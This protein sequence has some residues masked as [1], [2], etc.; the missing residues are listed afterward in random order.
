MDNKHYVVAWK[1]LRSGAFGC[2]NELLTLEECTVECNDLNETHRY[3]YYFPLDYDL[4]SEE[5]WFQFQEE[6]T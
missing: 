1:S 5:A 6:Y 3:K 4:T 2:R